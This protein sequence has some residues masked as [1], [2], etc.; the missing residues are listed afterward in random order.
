LY[1]FSLSVVF[2][3]IGRCALASL[4][5]PRHSTIS[6]EIETGEHRTN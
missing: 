3:V 5:I 4:P 6:I 2:S 1:E